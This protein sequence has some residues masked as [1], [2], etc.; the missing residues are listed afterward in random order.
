GRYVPQLQFL[1]ILLGSEPVLSPEERL[2]QR[3]LAGN[4][5]E[6]VDLAEQHEGAPDPTKFYEEAAIPALHF[7]E[8]DLSVDP[9]DLN[10]RRKVVECFDEVLDELEADVEV[11]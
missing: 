8:L 3:L 7:A 1:E 2:Y 9:A 11:D 5:S 6:A 4:A 10:Q